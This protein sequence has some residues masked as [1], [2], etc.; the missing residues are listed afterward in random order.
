M[1]TLRWEETGEE[2]PQELLDIQPDG[3]GRLDW[4]AVKESFCADVVILAGGASPPVFNQ[5]DASKGLTRKLFQPGSTI[6]VAVTRKASGAIPRSVAAH[7]HIEGS[8]M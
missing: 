6:F 4:A 3:R 7:F 8:A 2:S 1:V 5:E